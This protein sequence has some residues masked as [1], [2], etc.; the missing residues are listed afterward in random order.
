M[1]LA[2]DA[3]ATQKARMVMG[4]HPQHQG[5]RGQPD[6]GEGQRAGTDEG[7]QTGAEVGEQGGRE[8]GREGEKGE[9]AGS[10]SHQPGS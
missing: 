10:A 1:D 6:G 4:E 5:A 2:G 3:T 7:E 9:K 8:E